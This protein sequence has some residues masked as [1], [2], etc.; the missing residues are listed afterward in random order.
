[1]KVLIDANVLLDVLG[2]REPHYADSAQVWDL[3]EAGTIEGYVSAASLPTLFYILRRAK[4]TDAALEGIRLV[5]DTFEI[6]A[7]DEHVVNQALD[8]DMRDFEDAI[9]L[10]SS[11]RAG[12]VVLITR[13][14]KGFAASNL[15]VQTPRQFLV[16]RFPSG[17][18]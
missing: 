10:V 15:V 4:G 7:L 16:T 18:S 12:A 14:A 6:V 2:R 17:Q 3:A 5:R 8:S 1:M 9:Q 11:F 13:D